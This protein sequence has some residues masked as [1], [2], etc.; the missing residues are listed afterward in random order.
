MGVDPV[1]STRSCCDHQFMGSILTS[2][3]SWTLLL[4]VALSAILA[5][6]GADQSEGDYVALPETFDSRP[7]LRYQQPSYSN[8]A[9]DTYGHQADHAFPWQGLQDIGFHSRPRGFYS[10]FGD[11]LT[12]GYELYSWEE[13]RQPGQLIGSS[14]FKDW[15]SW[16]YVFDN[17][18]VGHDSH[19]SWGYS[20]IVGDGLIA[21]FTPLT[22]SMTDYNGARLDLSTPYF[23]L[24]TLASRIARPNVEWNWAQNLNPLEEHT[25]DSSMLLGTRAQADIGALQIGLNGVNVHAFRA[26]GTNNSMKG[27]LRPDHPLFEILILRFT[28][29]SPGDGAGGAVVQEVELIIDGDRRPDIR[30]RVIRHRSTTGTQVGRS[31]STGFLP[32]EYNNF[33]STILKS[34]GQMTAA[35]KYYRDQEIPLYADYL[36]RLGHEDP[37]FFLRL[38][39]GDTKWIDRNPVEKNTNLEG[40]VSTFVVESPDD[41]LAADGTD[42]LVYLFDLSAVPSIESVRVEAVVGNDYRV[43]VAKLYQFSEKPGNLDVKY[44]STVYETVLRAEGNV[45]DQSNIERVGFEVGT[46]TS[47]FTYSADLHLGLPGLEITGEYARSALFARFPSHVEGTPDFHSSPRFSDKGSAS[48][49]NGTSWFGQGRVGFELF[50]MN[51]DFTTDMVTYLPRE[52]GNV[53]YDRTA[54]PFFGLDNRTMI[55][56]LVQDNEDADRWPDLSMGVTVG[57]PGGD[58]CRAIDCDGTFP[59]QDLDNDGVTDT[60]RNLN[61]LP[62][63]EEP[64][65]MYDVDPNDFVYGMDRNNND[66]PDV[67]EDDYDA[68]Y[69]YDHD[70]R[71]YHLF[72]QYDLTPH[73]AVGVG[74]HDVEGVASGGRNNSTYA[75]VTYQRQGLER[76]RQV[77]FENHFRRVQDDIP[78]EY[79]RVRDDLEITVRDEAYSWGGPDGLKLI[80]NRDPIRTRQDLL[81]YE[82]SDVNET[83]LEGHWRPWSSLNFVQKLRLRLNWQQEGLL[84]SGTFQRS[85]RLD[86][87]NVVSRADYTRY[88]GALKIQPQ[89]KFMLLQLRDQRAERS[90]R[91]EV[92]LIP[93][94]R[95][96]FPLM[97][98]STL[99]VGIQGIGPFP[100]RFEDRV[101]ERNSFER[102]TKFVNLTNQSYYFGYQ[103]FTII[104]FTKDKQNYDDE[105]ESYREFD[106][107]SFFIRAVVGFNQYAR[108]L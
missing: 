2:T 29:D 63:Y 77:F 53:G 60:N 98:R 88:W 34:G 50:S 97:T 82:N 61:P 75:L 45:R 104:G 72:G 96:E 4:S 8:F 55:W 66:E 79:N 59:G 48:F 71:G 94:L 26:T 80:F 74:R 67:R 25:N 64:F 49:L 36:Y 85:R 46:N 95:A 101:A 13:R 56:R 89:F 9:W 57:S 44:R 1:M 27:I 17:L 76:L 84:P 7:F 102:R 40:L 30:P 43:E 32:I 42:A 69:P 52:A 86:Q 38:E 91:S 5:R 3:R 93:I 107:W 37:D 14:L 105:F 12:T 10:Q 106:T 11:Y 23:K 108:P 65:L 70:Q 54:D 51:P 39:N 15:T 31:L 81:F 92:S 41:I 68:D 58:E 28:D 100:Y 90:L 83:Y 18:V 20:L 21:R 103:L 6:A 19:R 35:R 16:F 33:V 73:W 47:I 78:D 22:L 99:Q 62:D 24:T 87:W